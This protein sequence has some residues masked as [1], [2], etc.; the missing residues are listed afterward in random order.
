[1]SLNDKSGVLSPA[2]GSRVEIVSIPCHFHASKYD[3]LGQ[4]FLPL[5]GSAQQAN[6]LMGV[7]ARGDRSALEA[8]AYM[9]GELLRDRSFAPVRSLSTGASNLYQLDFVA[10]QFQVESTVFSSGAGKQALFRVSIR[11]RIR[12]D[13]FQVF[14]SVTNNPLF[15]FTRIEADRPDFFEREF[16]LLAHESRKNLASVADR[17][18]TPAHEI[19]DLRLGVPVSGTIVNVRVQKAADSSVEVKSPTSS[20]IVMRLPFSSLNNIAKLADTVGHYLST[21]TNARKLLESTVAS[22]EPA[23]KATPVPEKGETS[24]STL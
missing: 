2:L 7:R 19:I 22:S 21:N 11:G 8:A 6:D 18:N 5:L 23:E 4:L 14:D 1:M 17:R 13:K 12:G 20:A 16:P 9:A 10:D 3:L 24:G 15:P